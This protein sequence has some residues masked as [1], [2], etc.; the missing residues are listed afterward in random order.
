MV[1]EAGV[2][3]VLEN[4]VGRDQRLDDDVLDVAPHLL[5]VVAEGLQVLVQGGQLPVGNGGPRSSRSQG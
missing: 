2:V 3:V 5:S 4:R 1:G